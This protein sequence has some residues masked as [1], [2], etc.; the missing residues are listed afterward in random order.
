[1]PT[2]TPI[3]H[4]FFL[5]FLLLFIVAPATPTPARPK[6]LGKKW[7][8]IP[9][10]FCTTHEDDGERACYMPL[11]M[12]CERS[13]EIVDVTET[14]FETVTVTMPYDAAV[15]TQVGYWGY[16]ID[17]H[18]NPM[19]APEDTPRNKTKRALAT[20][21]DTESP[22]PKP[23]P[24]AQ[25]QSPDSLLPRAAAAETITSR[26]DFTT[27]APAAL[28]REFMGDFAAQASATA[29][30]TVQFERLPELVIEDVQGGDGGGGVHGGFKRYIMGEE[31][32]YGDYE[33]D[34]GYDS[35]DDG[36][37]DDDETPKTPTPTHLPP[38]TIWANKPIL[39]VS[40]VVR[41]RLLWDD[42]KIT[43][44]P[45]WKDDTGCRRLFTAMDKRGLVTGY[46]CGQFAD[47]AT[48]S[49]H[50]EARGHR[51]R[52]PKSLVADAIRE[53]FGNENTLY[54]RGYE[55]ALL[56]ERNKDGW[57]SKT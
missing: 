19:K 31:E 49:F 16:D 38:K 56:C 50:M 35:G 28:F 34:D 25:H 32:P 27:R 13:G 3:Y 24:D 57:F 22:K 1:M 51:P 10:E 17:E 12:R 15:E 11:G 46:K 9:E 54:Y 33:H 2:P 7:C 23:H 20:N 37:S 5:L 43:W 40:C 8:K 29:R 36:D 26:F 30:P 41:A 6:H 39:E 53:G 47:P 52:F 21:P 44:G 18:G 42:F 45:A 14:V 55:N 4:F 48:N